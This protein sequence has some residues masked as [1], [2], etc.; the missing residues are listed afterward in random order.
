MRSIATPPLHSPDGISPSTNGAHYVPGG[1]IPIDPGLDGPPL[2]PA[3]FSG[4]E[5]TPNMQVSVLRFVGVVVLNA[6]EQTR[7]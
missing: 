3:L 6:G 7:T 5:C 2:D 1:D 4:P